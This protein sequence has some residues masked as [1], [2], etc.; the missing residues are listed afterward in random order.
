MQHVKKTTTLFCALMMVTAAAAAQREWTVTGQEVP[1][2]A[3][4]DEMI[5]GQMMTHDISA[6]DRK[7]V[8]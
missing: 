6:S 8:V 1:E 7:S 4:I 2:L 3:A 5:R